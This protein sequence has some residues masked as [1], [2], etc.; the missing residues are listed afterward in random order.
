MT[1]SRNLDNLKPLVSFLLNMVLVLMLL[2]M[3]VYKN[4]M[5][6]PPNSPNYQLSIKKSHFTT[7]ERSV[8]IATI[9]VVS[10]IE[11]RRKDT[12][13]A[14]SLGILFIRELT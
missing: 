5:S 3:V 7:L 1:Q 11:V 9:V 14:Y 6:Q 13:H 8:V 12:M 4:C 2:A 10:E